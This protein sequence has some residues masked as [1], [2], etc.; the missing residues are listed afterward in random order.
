MKMEYEVIFPR[1]ADDAIRSAFASLLSKQGKVRGDTS[2]K[3]DR[4]KVIC[5]VKID[6]K[7]VAIGGIKKKTSSDFGENKAAVSGLEKEFEW[8]LGYLYTEE[9]CRGR[10]IASNIVRLLVETIGD[11][12]LMAST[13]I[14][15]NPNMVKI[16][17][18]AGFRIYG[19][20]WRSAIHGNYLGLFLKFKG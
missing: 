7:V 3:I 9:I 4:C 11:Q 6:G 10:G 12:N 17:E 14:S 20:P 2:N 1:D 16:L 8:E 18:G 5:I 15:V 13:E 19:K